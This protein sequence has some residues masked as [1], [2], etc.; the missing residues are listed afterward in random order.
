MREFAFTIRYESGVDRLMDL[1]IDNPD[2]KAKSTACCATV[3]SMWRIDHLLGIEEVLNRIDS[4]FLHEEWCN[5]CLHAP[6]CNST[7]H[8]SLMNR[9]P[10]HRVVY[11]HREEIER[12]HSIPYL[13]SSHIGD[14]VLFEA[15]RRGNEYR[16]KVLMP[17]DE[18]VG[19]LYDAIE[20]RMR[21]GLELDL[22]RIAECN[23]WNQ[24]SIAAAQ[25]S[26]EQQDAVEAAVEHGYYATPRGTTVE[27]LSDLL[28]VPRSTLQYRLQGAEERIVKR[29][30]DSS[31]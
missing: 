17:S 4:I 20:S 11:T 29:F 3:D 5:E 7:R 24:Q 9:S 18:A 31:L 19:A 27:E 21:D 25:L 10:T 16:W 2:A 14:G 13:A 1:F 12:C 8:H 6:N 23:D 28:E 15:E 22:H 26:P 30:A